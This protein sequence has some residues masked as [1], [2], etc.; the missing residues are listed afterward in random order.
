[1]VDVKMTALTSVKLSNE[2]RPK[3]ADIVPGASGKKTED[4]KTKPTKP[5]A[6]ILRLVTPN[7]Q[8]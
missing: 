3:D 2:N 1:V 8:L 6:V 7:E 4:L 5:S